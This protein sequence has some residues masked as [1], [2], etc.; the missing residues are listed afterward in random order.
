[1]S[2]KVVPV[3]VVVPCFNSASTVQRA[4]ESVFR[5]TVQVREILVVD[6][7]STD[8]TPAILR[9]IKDTDP[10]AGCMR[11]IYLKENK[12][13]SY[14]RNVAWDVAV[15]DYVAFLDSD[16]EWVSNK[17]ELQYNWMKKHPS[18]VM[19]GHAWSLRRPVSHLSGEFRA[20]R[21]SKRLLLLRNVFATPC[22]MV[23][24][25]IELRFPTE[26][27]YSE[28]YLLWL[29]LACRGYDIAY[30][31]VPLTVIHKEPFG[32][33]GLSQN[34]WAMQLG[35]IGCFLALRRQRFISLP[36]FLGA[37]LL[38]WIKYLRRL[39]IVRCRDR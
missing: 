36:A 29:L 32:A 33:G 34:L 6:D 11:V 22:V 17:I 31:P 9:R 20:K 35:E 12:G 37:C 14:A 4:L 18:V 8:G 26:Q 15:G 10:R 28:D 5:Q 24:R 23:K 21:I 3:S 2:R 30:L 39:V 16:D 13:P 1:M 27:R 25:S 19:S 38:S 7:G